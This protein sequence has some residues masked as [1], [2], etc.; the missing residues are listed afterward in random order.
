MKELLEEIKQHSKALP[1]SVQ[2][3][4]LDFIKFKEQKLNQDKHTLLEVSMLSELALSQWNNKEEDDA[5]S[6][7]Q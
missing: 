7:Y 2:R 5:W 1:D 4:V 6:S 3:E